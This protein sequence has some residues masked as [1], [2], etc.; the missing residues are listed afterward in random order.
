[1]WFQFFLINVLWVS[2]WFFL[3]GFSIMVYGVV[4]CEMMVINLS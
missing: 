4:M 1:M 2:V 3:V